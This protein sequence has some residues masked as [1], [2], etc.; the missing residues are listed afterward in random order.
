ME[1]NKLLIQ[2]WVQ[3]LLIGTVVP[4]LLMSKV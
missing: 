4:L 3:L 2:I 1:A